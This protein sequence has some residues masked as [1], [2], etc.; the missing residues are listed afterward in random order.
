[1]HQALLL[2]LLRDGGRSRAELGDV[3]ELSRSKLNVELDRLIELGL[4]EPDGLAASRGGRRSG[5][6][7]LSRQTR[8]VGIDVGATSIDIAVTDGELEILGHVS[9]SCDIR[10]GPAVVL[11]RAMELLG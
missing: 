7:R 10:Q 6:V 2:R 4:A 9:E 5:K 3:V 11:D 8:F 1:V